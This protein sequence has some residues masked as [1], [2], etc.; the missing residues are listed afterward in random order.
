MQD[1]RA[2]VPVV[3]SFGRQ[4]DMEC[5]EMANKGIFAGDPEA[6]VKPPNPK[7]A[8]HHWLEVFDSDGH[9]FGLVVAQWNPGAQ[10]WSHSGY[11]GS[12]LYLDTRYW[13]YVAPC[14]M[15]EI[16]AGAEGVGLYCG[17]VVETVDDLAVRVVAADGERWQFRAASEDD[18]FNHFLWKVFSRLAR[19]P[20]SK[21]R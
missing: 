5:K 15:P 14:Q 7:A 20:R 9:S 6:V 18:P 8:E 3:R 10:K 2:R 1:L 13:R 17:I 12:G 16:P 11:V 19:S 21:E 4:T